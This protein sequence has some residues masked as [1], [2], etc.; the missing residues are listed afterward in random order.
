M[1]NWSAAPAGQKGAKDSQQNLRWIIAVRRFKH[2]GG[3]LPWQHRGE[4]GTEFYTSRSEEIS[5]ASQSENVLVTVTWKKTYWI[6]I[7]LKYP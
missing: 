4:D 2:T 5:Q 1:S 3:N 6:K 7:A